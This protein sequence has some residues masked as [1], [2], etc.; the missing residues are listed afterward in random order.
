MRDAAPLASALWRRLD[1]VGC[2]VARLFETPAGWRLEGT[3]VFLHET[4]RAPARLD[5]TVELNRDW[6]TT[7]GNV[8]GF[9]GSSAVAA[10]ISRDH[11]G[12]SINGERVAGP[13]LDAVVDLDFGFTPATNFAQVRR[14]DLPVGQGTT[15]SVAWWDVGQPTLTALP[16]HYPRTSPSTYRYASPTGPYEADLEF[17]ASGFVRHYPDLWLL[18]SNAERV[19]G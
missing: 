2:D 14:I 10:T 18:E 15:F 4:S 13:G 1:T 8:A 7:R 5:Y 9:V 17:A 12:W 19:A 11:S 6:T 16:Q 3:T